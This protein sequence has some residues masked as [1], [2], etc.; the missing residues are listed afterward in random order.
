MSQ[1]ACITE[2]QTSTHLIAREK[3]KPEVVPVFSE[4]DLHSPYVQPEMS[5]ARCDLHDAKFFQEEVLRLVNHLR[6]REQICGTKKMAA[7]GPVIWNARLQAAAF[8]HSAQMAAT[9][10]FS[11]T[12]LDGRQLR[13]RV[14][15]TGYQYRMLGEN[16]AAGKIDIAK[17]IKGW[18]ESP[19]HCEE[20]LHPE[21]TEIAVA[22]VEKKNSFYTRYW[23]MNLGK[24][25]PLTK[26]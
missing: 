2:Y 11:H 12:S 25:L 8:E 24:P 22:C 5:N 7:S 14:L 23:T 13:D 9:N 4:R 1:A 3:V 15:A 17:V 18:L 20:M 26:P 16:I 19:P 21:F 6:A 10:L